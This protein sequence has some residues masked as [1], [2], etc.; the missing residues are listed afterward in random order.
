[1][2]QS[3]HNAMDRSYTGCIVSSGQGFTLATD[4]RQIALNGDVDFNKHV[5]HTVKVTGEQEG[6]N[7]V[8]SDL[9]HISATCDPD[10]GATASASDA[11]AQAREAGDRNIAEN[12]RPARPST[13]PDDVAHVDPRGDI[14]P[15]ADVD[16]NAPAALHD[17]DRVPQDRRRG[18]TA[19]DQSNNKSDRKTTAAI[20]KSIVKDDSLSTYAHNVKIITRDGRVTLRGPVRS[21][22]EK[23]TV[24]A[25]AEKIVGAGAVD[26]QMTID[27]DSDAHPPQRNQK[28][29]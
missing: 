15:R 10:A 29:K 3:P 26:D 7:Y 25:K 24:A 19:D 8:V 6:T 23:A 27:P 9:E 22:A 14:E 1:M 5:G 16:V 21:A 4:G 12:D 28:E 18:V 20:R 2:A 17:D 11:R 13:D